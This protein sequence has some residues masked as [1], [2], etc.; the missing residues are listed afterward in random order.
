VHRFYAP[1][2]DATGDVELPTDEAQ[3]LARVLR[4]EAGDVVAIFDGRGREAE[5]RVETVAARRVTVRVTAPRIAAAEPVV[6]ITLGQALLKSDKMDRVIR[7]AVMLGVSAIQPFASARSDVPLA[8]LRSGVRRERWDRAVIATVKQ[9]GRA[10]VPQVLEAIDFHD[11]IAGNLDPVRLMFVEP[12]VASSP[13][14]TDVRSLEAARPGA[15]TLIIGPEGGWEQDEISTAAKAGV[16]LVTLG[17]ITLRADAMAGA[18]IAV[19][20]YAW[21]DL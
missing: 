9:C 18:A 16:A 15:A 8:A 4:L 11:M 19:L 2:F 13:P 5:A 21:R 3:H 12:A 17:Q 14:R 1:G 10:V 7:D 20:R 6:S